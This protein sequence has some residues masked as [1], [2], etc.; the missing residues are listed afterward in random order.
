MESENPKNESEY[1]A[2]QIQV[3]EGLQAVRKRPAMYI[4]DTGVRGLHHLIYE[5]VDN[6]IDEALAGYCTEII[7]VL[8]KDGSCTVIDNGRGIPV[9]IHPTEGRPA[10]EVVMTKL[11][12]GGKFEKKA[13][14]V[15]GGLHG[16]G[17][18]AVNALSKTLIVTVKRDGKL[19][20]QEYAK[21]NPVADMKELG[22]SEGTGT[23]VKFYPDT[24]IFPETLFQYE[25]VESRLR[26]LAFLNKGIKIALKDDRT[27]KEEVFQYEGGLKA[28]VEYL[29]KGKVVLHEIIYIEKEKA[30]T[31]VELAMQYNEAYKET[32]FSFANDINTHEG[33]THLNG[34]KAALTRAINNYIKKNNLGE[35][36]SGEDSREGLTAIV[37]VKLMEPQFE[38]QTKTKLGNSDIKGIVESMVSDKL[39]EFLEEHPAI[40]KAICAKCMIA[41]RAREA[42]IKARELT[43]RK[44]VLNHGSLPGKLADCSSR[45]PAKSELFIVEGDSAGGCF[46]GDT[47]V[48]LVDGRNLTFKQL[49]E[50]NKQGKRIFCYTIKKDGTIGIEE[51]KNPRITKRNAEVIKVALDNGE[52]IICTP[53]HL[54]MTRDGSYKKAEQIT[55]KDSLMPF[56]DR[57]SENH[58]EPAKEA[59]ANYNHKIARIE[60]LNNQIDV[61][62]I[63]VPNTHNFALASGV[64]VHN[65]AK[66]GRNRDIQAILPLRGKILNVEKARLNKIIENEQIG[67]LITVLGTG[68]SDEFKLEEARYHKII[69]M[70]DADVD[71]NHIACLLLTFFFRY[72]KPLIEAGYVYLAQPPLYGI[73]K[74]NSIRYVF[75]DAEKDKLVSELGKDV[76][77]QR[78]KGL[79][80]MNPKQLWETTMDPELRVLKQITIEDAILADQTFT[81]LMGE[82]VE[83]RRRFIETHA[84]EVKELD[85]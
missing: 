5:V 28:F 67:I 63:E 9:D 57:L 65:S 54:F 29:N 74:G 41:A 43:R 19:Y 11:H 39:S 33:G 51:I 45:E 56:A 40:A 35:Q 82:E 55:I 46:S 68:I 72:M 32:V 81:M 16:V 47:K 85:I 66:Q 21:G 1:K 80:E 79:G 8:N 78:Y 77:I 49:V 48:A 62:D 23:E 31:G 18:S 84:K 3:L 26:E 58:L 59:V 38:G 75:N 7:V 22:T 6:S 71:G 37:S 17:V 36:I 27:G 20:S 61:Y 44:G 30:E 14:K 70:T 4:G 53:D 52:E 76:N 13:Y 42:A 64:F 12:A 25:I 73:K 2:K 83:P 24:E 60:R 15:S 69:I 34:F 50:E 10:L